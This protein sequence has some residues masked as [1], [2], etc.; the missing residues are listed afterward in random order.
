MKFAKVQP[1]TDWAKYHTVELATLRVPAEVRDGAPKG[2]RPGF[3]E[4]Y[5]LR[6]QDVAALQDAYAGAMRDELGKAGFTFVTTPGPDTLII[7]GQILNIQL[8]APIESTRQTYT[9]R[10]A[11]FSRDAGSMAMGL[12]FGDGASGQVIAE[13]ADQSVR[14]NVWGMNNRTTNLAEAKYAFRRWAAAIRERL[15]SARGS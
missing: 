10:G 9:S 4:S 5:V 6:D 13:A 2:T 11:T 14:D 8:T 1:G 15:V 7:L 12:V 3:G